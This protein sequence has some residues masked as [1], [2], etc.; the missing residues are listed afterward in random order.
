VSYSAPVLRALVVFLASCACACAERRPPP[1]R[2]AAAVCIAAIQTVA[3]EEVDGPLRE[4]LA[5]DRLYRDRACAAAW[6]R[7][8]TPGDPAEWSA[9]VEH[10]IPTCRA[11][12]VRQSGGA[13]P[14][15][16]LA[17]VDPGDDKRMHELSAL[18][19]L[20]RAMHVM[21]GIPDD[22]AD[23]LAS[24]ASLLALAV[25]RGIVVP[26]SGPGVRAAPRD[27]ELLV[28]LDAAGDVHLD[29][30]VVPG[31][32]LAAELARAIARHRPDA[33]LLEVDQDV[34]YD[35]IVAVMDALRTAG[36]DQVAFKLR[37]P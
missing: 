20:D 4:A 12:C 32:R 29:G 30:R 11:A 9:A 36:I 13:P 17:P 15:G 19:E 21:S 33:A 28:G 35:R 7:L 24:R 34:P 3:S 23:M 8:T 18:F 16:C 14:R 2:D 37:E 10:L 6:R 22:D 27:G 1:P 31:D 26:V 25:P 5:C